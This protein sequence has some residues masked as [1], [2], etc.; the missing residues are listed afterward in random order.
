[1]LMRAL[2]SGRCGTVLSLLSELRALA[3]TKRAL[4]TSPLQL[5]V[6]FILPAQPGVLEERE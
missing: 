1:M 3:L 6:P 4:E 5:F 2:A